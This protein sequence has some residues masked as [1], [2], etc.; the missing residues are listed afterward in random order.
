MMLNLA[1]QF[2]ARGPLASDH[3]QRH[4]Q[5]H[6]S[7]NDADRD[8]PVGELVH[9]CI[10][11][12][13]WRGHDHAG[14]AWPQY[15]AYHQR[16]SLLVDEV[17]LVVAGGAIGGPALWQIA[18]ACGVAAVHAV[19][20]AKRQAG[21]H[22]RRDQAFRVDQQGITVALQQHVLVPAQA[23]DLHLRI[24]PHAIGR[25][26]A[27]R[28][29]HQR[30]HQRAAGRAGDLAVLQVQRALHQLRAHAEALH[31]Q[32]PVRAAGGFATAAHLPV[33]LLQDADGAAD[34][35]TNAAGHIVQLHVLLADRLG[36]CLVQRVQ[37]RHRCQQG[38][39]KQ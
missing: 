6:Q 5:H 15:A 24:D 30:L 17:A 36:A 21:A 20:Q 25:T 1:Q 4:A 26:R 11:G 31:A 18:F 2:G 22:E 39:G 23:R 32:Q 19:E 38:R 33:Q 9:A 7:G 3:R 37:H 8:E 29:Q 34:L 12:G 27:V 14:A 28:A 35:A 16:V 10:E 13:Q